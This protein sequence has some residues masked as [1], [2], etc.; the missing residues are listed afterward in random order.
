[1]IIYLDV[2]VKRGVKYDSQLFV[3]EDWVGVDNVVYQNV[4]YYHP[5]QT[6]LLAH[7]RLSKA[8]L[9]KMSSFVDMLLLRALGNI[10]MEMGGTHSESCL[11]ICMG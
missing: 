5:A 3:L 9:F 7:P 4:E 6:K 2:W 8:L 1:M 10:H 11:E